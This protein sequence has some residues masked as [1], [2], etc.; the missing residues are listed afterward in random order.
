MFGIPANLIVYGLIAAAGFGAGWSVNGWRLG[1]KVTTLTA[2][3]NG[4]ANGLEVCNTS[5][6]SLKAKGA[7]NEA[8]AAIDSANA[9]AALSAALVK[10]NKRGKAPDSCDAAFEALDRE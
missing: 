2:E 4:Y 10:A 7:A 8:Q 6:D 9:R 1:S 5:I 3:R